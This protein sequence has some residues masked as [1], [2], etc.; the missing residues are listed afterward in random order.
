MRTIRTLTAPRAAQVAAGALILALPSSAY[1]LTVGA[2][3][4][5]APVARAVVRTWPQQI[6][7]RYGRDATV[8]GDVAG[9]LGRAVTLEF[10]AAGSGRWRALASTHPGPRGGFTLRAPVRHSGHLRVAEALTAEPLATIASAARMRAPAAAT[11]R[12]AAISVAAAFRVGAGTLD[13]LTGRPV[14][15]S[16]RL[17]PAAG[18]RVI[19]LLSGSGT[20]WTAIASA[21]TGNDGHFVLRFAV[22]VAETTGLRVDFAGDRG[23]LATSA[24]AGRLVTMTERVASWY[25]DGGST[26]CGF[27]ATFGIASR[28]LPCGS[29]VTLSYHGHTVT[30]TVD[31]RGPFV[32]GR[33]YDLNQ[34]TAAA[35]GMYGVATVLSS[36]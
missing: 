18:G 28:T 35:L 4:M 24:T 10:Q 5:P 27:H 9:G 8:R 20:R 15:L 19:R 16:G 34:N 11:S 14:S 6:H 33:D 25:Y 23:N 31:D 7:L 22:P 12:P 1:A 36:V 30:A 2:A 26:A 3:P 13:A 17:L 32:A 29:H 21:P